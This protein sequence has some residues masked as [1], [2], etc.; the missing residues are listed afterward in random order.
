MDNGHNLG[1][2]D[3]Q[4]EGLGIGKLV[5]LGNN[6]SSTSWKL[7]NKLLTC[8]VCFYRKCK[9]IRSVMINIV[10]FGVEFNKRHDFEYE[11]IDFLPKKYG[12]ITFKEIPEAWVCPIDHCLEKMEDPTKVTKMS[13]YSGLLVIHCGEVSEYDQK[14]LTGL[15]RTVRLID[16]DLHEQ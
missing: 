14:L 9:G 10:Q 4:S 15:D 11:D 16:L 6:R 13:Q 2:W 3:C 8:L 5:I 12:Y 1:F 7:F